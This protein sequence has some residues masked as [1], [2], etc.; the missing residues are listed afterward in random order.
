ML[1]IVNTLPPSGGRLV[2]DDY[3]PFSFR[4]SEGV[5][6]GPYLWRTG[7]LET[8][9]LEITID[10]DLHTI[11]G[12]TLTCFSGRLQEEVPQGYENAEVVEGIPAVDASV[13]PQQQNKNALDFQL[14]R[15]DEPQEIRAYQ[16]GSSVFLVFGEGMP[17][18]CIKTDRVGFFERESRLCGIGFF[19]LSASEI[20][21]VIS[22]L[23]G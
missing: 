18:R 13:F 16:K 10:R 11:F 15:H 4:L 9:L 12:V 17:N 5:L 6:P 21:T 20:S 1:R 2:I 3:I 22:L 14:D 7:N 8:S 23:Q 19:D